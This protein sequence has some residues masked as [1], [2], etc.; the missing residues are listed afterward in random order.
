MARHIYVF[1]ICQIPAPLFMTWFISGFWVPMVWIFTDSLRFSSASV[2]HHFSLCLTMEEEKVCTTA[3]RLYSPPG[4]MACCGQLWVWHM[5]CSQGL[6]WVMPPN[7]N[8]WSHWNTIT[9][10]R[11]TVSRCLNFPA[12][13]EV[14]RSRGQSQ[15]TWLPPVPTHGS[16][17]VVLWLF[18]FR[19][20]PSMFPHRQSTFR[21]LFPGVPS[22]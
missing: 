17:W 18:V 22:H 12:I 6:W 20:A 16:T 4:Y 2:H 3:Y 5:F 8:H 10:V 21:G 13:P 1:V 15:Y 7:K 14:T 9:F 11:H 19:S